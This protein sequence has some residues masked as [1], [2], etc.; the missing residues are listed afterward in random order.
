M[1]P[2]PLTQVS[3]PDTFQPKVV[4]LYEALFQQPDAQVEE[5]ELEHSEGF[6]QEFFLHKPDA[7]NLRRVLRDLSPDAMLHLQVENEQSPLDKTR[8]MCL[9]SCP[10]RCPASSS[11]PAQLIVCKP[12]EVRRTRSRSM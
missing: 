9:H 6:W 8:H 4:Q 11:S 1:E 7:P 12:P 5:Q 3:R 2:S 10:P